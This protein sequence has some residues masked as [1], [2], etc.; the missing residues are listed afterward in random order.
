MAARGYRPAGPFTVPT[1]L[2][3]PTYRR[4]KGVPEKIWPDP[5]IVTDDNTIFI[6]FRTFGGT[7]STENGV[8]SVVST[9]VVDTW[10]RPDITA[11]CRLYLIDTGE[12]YEIL[13]D[14]EDIERRHQYLR[15]K[16]KRIGGGA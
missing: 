14:P 16:V 12:L 3:I 7:E 5:A 4:V 8:L 9:G 15:I 11:A 6:N 1:R 13:G 10:Y 2:L